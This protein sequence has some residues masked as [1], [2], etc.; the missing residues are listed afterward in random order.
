MYVLAYLI[1]LT[2][3]TD[4]LFQVW[5]AAGTQIFYSLGIGFGSLETLASYNLFHNN[6]YR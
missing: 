3:S 1:K 5:Y 4:T 6:I 2:K